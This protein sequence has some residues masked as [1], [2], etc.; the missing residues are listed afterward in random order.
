M[1][2]DDLQEEILS[3][4]EDNYVGVDDPVSLSGVRAMLSLRSVES[5][6]DDISDALDNLEA[7]GTVWVCGQIAYYLRG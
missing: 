1:D 5:N 4:L 3:V 2:I 7:V 6:L